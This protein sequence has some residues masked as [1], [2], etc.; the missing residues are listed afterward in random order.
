MNT[1][2]EIHYRIN[3]EMY[4]F[5]KSIQ[6]LIAAYKATFREV[7]RIYI[8]KIVDERT[9]DEKRVMRDQ[10]VVSIILCNKRL[11]RLCAKFPK[12]GF[13]VTFRLFCS[14]DDGLDFE[15]TSIIAK[16][17]KTGRKFF[18][19]ETACIKKDHHS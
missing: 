16:D 12:L 19:Y 4:T 7:E 6:A 5:N 8:K 15:V 10:V 1:I 9:K 2:Q 14:Y 3:R 18:C 11:L 13:D 17:P